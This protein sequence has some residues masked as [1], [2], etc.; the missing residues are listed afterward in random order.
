MTLLK[1]DFIDWLSFKDVLPFE[2]VDTTFAEFCAQYSAVQTNWAYTYAAIIGIIILLI[3]NVILLV[4][5]TFMDVTPA[6]LIFTPLF[7]PI[8][9]TFGMSPIQFGMILVYIP[10][11][12]GRKS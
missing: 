3:M 10:A 4:A 2:G 6:I 5:G 11:T 12:I 1:L 8:V 9:Q 7:L